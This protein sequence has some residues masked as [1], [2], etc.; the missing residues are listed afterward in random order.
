MLKIIG[1][2]LVVM[3][4]FFASSF[5]CR[6]E[7]ESVE[8]GKRIEAQNEIMEY[9]LRSENRI[10]QTQRALKKVGLYQGE[11]DGRMNAQMNSAVI[12]FQRSKGLSADGIVGSRTWE[13]LKKYLKD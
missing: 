5:S 8:K 9:R 11:I 4:A 10:Q 1:V 6:R 12:D 13:E 2:L 3:I 7:S